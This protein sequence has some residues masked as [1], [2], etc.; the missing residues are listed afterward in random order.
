MQKANFDSWTIPSVCWLLFMPWSGCL[1]W[2]PYALSLSYSNKATWFEIWN[3][4][5]SPFQLHGKKHNLKH[6]WNNHV[7]SLFISL[8]RIKSEIIK[9]KK[10]SFPN[11]FNVTAVTDV[12]PLESIHSLHPGA[13]FRQMDPWMLAV[14]GIWLSSINSDKIGSL[15][16]VRI[17]LAVIEINGFHCFSYLQIIEKN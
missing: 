14:L 12:I 16:N 15:Y 4:C 5:K 3:W 10:I 7:I 13:L 8:S 9:K 6:R 11:D 2:G 17:K 1:I